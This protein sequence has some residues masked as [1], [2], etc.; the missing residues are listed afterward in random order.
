MTD[1]TALAATRRAWHAVAELVLAGPQYRRTGTIRLAVTPAGFATVKEPMLAVVGTDLVAGDGRFA[2][3]GATGADLAAAAGVDVGPPVG[4]YHD[5]P[6]V[7]P[8]EVLRVDPDAAGTLAAAFA[9][10]EAALRRLAPDQT[11][12]LWPEHFDLGV[13]LDEVNFGV[14]PGDGYLDEPYAYVGPWTP[15]TGAFWNTPFGAARAVRDLATVDA[16]LAFFTEGRQLA[17]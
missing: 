10:G 7:A 11:P 9:T 5:G 2:I 13:S 12:V 14:S 3:D 6:G 1:P 16:V 17:R 15:R 4:L 8:D